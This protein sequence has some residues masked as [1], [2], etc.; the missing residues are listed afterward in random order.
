MVRFIISG[1]PLYQLHLFFKGQGNYLRAMRKNQK[2]SREEMYLAIEI[3]QESGLT[4]TEFCKREGLP[5]TSFIHWVQ[6]FN[7]EKDN[8]NYL[9]NNYP[10][11]IPVKVT[12]PE[13]M[14]QSTDDRIVVSFPNGVKLNLP[15]GTDITQLKN[16]INS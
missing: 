1:Y 13:K 15:A 12:E 3:W 10:G 4:K 14:V 2:Y 11:F 5:V 8:V 6:K 9:V 16:L 7:R